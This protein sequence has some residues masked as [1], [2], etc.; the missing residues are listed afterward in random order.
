MLEEQAIVTRVEGRQ[1]YVKSLQTSACGHCVQK[2]SCS[3][4]LYAKLLPVREMALSSSLALSAG[5][6]VIVAIEEQHLLRASLLIYLVPLLIMLTTV[7]LYQG[8][9]QE[10]AL[11]AIFSLAASLYVIHRL[12]NVFTHQLMSAPR[13][14]KKI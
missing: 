4:A 1:V 3:T 12:Q 8:P 6:K 11:V 5:D 10:V 9:E 7:G 13:I 14:I 2:Q